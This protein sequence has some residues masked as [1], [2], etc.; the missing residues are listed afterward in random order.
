[1]KA[2]GVLRKR[3]E[4]YQGSIPKIHTITCLYLTRD[5]PHGNGSVKLGEKIAVLWA[6]GREKA[7]Y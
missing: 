4:A 7:S 1:M 5:Y 6:E 2:R 3:E